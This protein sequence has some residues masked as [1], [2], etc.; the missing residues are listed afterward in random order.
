MP[1]SE[2]QTKRVLETTCRSAWHTN[3]SLSMLGVQHRDDHVTWQEAVKRAHE[4]MKTDEWQMAVFWYYHASNK[5]KHPSLKKYFRD[6]SF[7]CAQPEAREALFPCVDVG[8]AADA[9]AD[10]EAKAEVET[11]A[12]TSVC[13]ALFP[14]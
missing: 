11:E 2:P 4:C 5:A 6:T 9:A 14:F 12:T 1:K 3:V 10:A 13:D 8:V 7:L